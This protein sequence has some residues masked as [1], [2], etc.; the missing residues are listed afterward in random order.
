VGRTIRLWKTAFFMGD[1]GCASTKWVSR[2]Q[3]RSALSDS[4]NQQNTFTVARPTHHF[5]PL[6]PTPLVIL[7]IMVCLAQACR[8]TF[9]HLGPH[10]AINRLI[11][12]AY[13]RTN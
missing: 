3:A 2:G 13:F 4:T 9:P 5:Y 7:G 11:R 6:P 10:S 12:L 1:Q 8:E